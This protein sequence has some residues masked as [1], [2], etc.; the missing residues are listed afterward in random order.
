MKKIVVLF[1][2]A[3]FI[4]APLTFAQKG[5]AKTEMR[6]ENKINQL[7]ELDLSEDQREKIEAIH[8]KYK[9]QQE[10]NK[11]EMVKLRE[12]RKNIQQAKKT[13]VKAVLTP[14]QIAKMDAL[15]KERQAKRQSARKEVLKERMKTET[16]KVEK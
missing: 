13:E 1:A 16:E 8:T 3:T 12:E 10:A 7:K 14:E 6:K 15:Q 11:K 9:S 2:F 5:E 4:V